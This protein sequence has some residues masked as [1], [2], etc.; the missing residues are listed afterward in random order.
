M[1]QNQDRSETEAGSGTKAGQKQDRSGMGNSHAQMWV[2]IFVAVYHVKVKSNSSFPLGWE[3]DENYVQNENLP[4][5][6]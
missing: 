4:S 5:N 6:I 1:G 3:F 2:R